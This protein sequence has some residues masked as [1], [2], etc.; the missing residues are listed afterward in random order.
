MAK[1]NQL[2]KRIVKKTIPKTPVKAYKNPEFLTSPDARAIRM[3]AEFLEPSGRLRRAGIRDTIVFFGSARL[4]SREDALKEFHKM[5]RLASRKTRDYGNVI[6]QFQDAKTNLEMSKYYEDAAQLAKLLTKWSKRLFHLSRFV[7][8]SGGGPGIMEA[9][10]KGAYEAG[11]R[12]L[13]LNI[14]LPF[15]QYP[16][17]YISKELNFVFHYFF[18]RKFWFVYLAKAL[19]VFPGGFGT[20]DELMEVLTLLQTQ[21]LRKKITVVLYGKEFWD[22]VIDIDALVRMRLISPSDVGLFTYADSPEEAFKYLVREL[23]K[24]Y[25]DETKEG[26]NRRRIDK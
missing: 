23:R 10:N 26:R 5:E 14:S 6:R 21:K 8:C 15:E 18:M 1:H 9:A 2:Q 4:K 25:P 17:K 11:G 22:R 12:S 16:N 20:L 7:V 24:N 3:L 19:V 13:G